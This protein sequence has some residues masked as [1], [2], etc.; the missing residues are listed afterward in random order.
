MNGLEETNLMIGDS[1]TDPEEFIEF[2]AVSIERE[3]AARERR[4]KEDL[5]FLEE[6]RKRMFPTPWEKDL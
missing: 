3:R 5:L 6:K 4:R 2:I 1:V